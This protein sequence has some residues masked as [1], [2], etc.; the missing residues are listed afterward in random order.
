MQTGSS[1]L[2]VWEPKPDGSPTCT[3]RSPAHCAAAPGLSARCLGPKHS[4]HAAARAGRPPPRAPQGAPSAH[5]RLQRPSVQNASVYPQ[6]DMGNGTRYCQANGQ[7]ASEKD[8][9]HRI[10]PVVVL[11]QSKQ[12]LILWFRTPRPWV[13][14]LQR[15]GWTC[16]VQSLHSRGLL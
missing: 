2:L 16:L 11:D 6:R 9:A 13:W 5:H 4:L 3:Q 1:A 8:K 7:R 14:A 15:L 12:E 10:L